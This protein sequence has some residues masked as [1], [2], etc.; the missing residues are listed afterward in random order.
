M[1]S[2]HEK[3]S[4]RNSMQELILFLLGSIETNNVFVTNFL[5]RTIQYFMGFVLS[6]FYQYKTKK[7]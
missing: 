4:R 3:L 2:F 7:E 6:P 1:T 5:K